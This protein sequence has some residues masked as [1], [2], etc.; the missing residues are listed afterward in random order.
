[1]DGATL[2][3]WRWRLRGAWM[4]PTFVALTF[5]DGAIASWLPVFTDHDNVVGGWLYSFIYTLVAIIVFV[6]PLGWVV[7]RF[8]RDM[9]KVVARDYAGGLVC[10]GMTA[11]FLIA[12][13]LNHPNV[14]TDNGAIQNAT[15]DAEAYIGFRAPAQF[16]TNLHR[17]DT[18]ALQP[19]RIYR[20][21]ATDTA[22]TR[23]YCVVVD[24]SK[25]FGRNVRYSGS[26]PNSVLSEG[27]S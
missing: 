14:V 21:C 25:P 6:P 5:L 7:R 8:R 3:R 18:Y 15:A 26:E 19:P 12:G 2:T 20:V 11:T 9:P 27:T 22:G 13:V 23:D 1:M 16:R 24:L 17:L 10:I 4:W